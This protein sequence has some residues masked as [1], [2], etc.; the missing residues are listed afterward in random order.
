[1]NNFTG[2]WPASFWI[3]QSFAAKS[4][5]S[6]WLSS[7]FF[8][9]T[10]FIIFFQHP[11]A[12]STNCYFLL[13]S[14]NLFFFF[15]LLCTSAHILFFSFLCRTHWPLVGHRRSAVAHSNWSFTNFW[16]PTDA[17]LKAYFCALNREP[18]ITPTPHSGSTSFEAQMSFLLLRCHIYFD[19]SLFLLSIIRFTSEVEEDGGCALDYTGHIVYSQCPLIAVRSGNLILPSTLQRATAVHC[20]LTALL[21]I[22]C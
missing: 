21:F 1:M 17:H 2:E 11:P 22:Q 18:P 6:D 15:P 20:N 7:S 19:Y 12:R 5:K 14:E 4:W 8:S 10:T 9:R 13:V 16:S 3:N